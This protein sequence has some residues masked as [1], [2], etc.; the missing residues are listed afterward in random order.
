MI[1]NRDT[2]THEDESLPTLH[3]TIRLPA[4]LWRGIK[5]RGSRE[6]KAVRIVVREALATQLTPL[7]GK[8]RNLGLRGEVKA[9]KLVRV[10]LDDNAIGLLNFGRRQTGLPAVQML[11]LCLARHTARHGSRRMTI[12]VS[13]ASRK[14]D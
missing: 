12:A 1:E 11:L 14:H 13:W 5:A 6:G 10:P 7:V 2:P 9:D 3:R 8:L 4:G